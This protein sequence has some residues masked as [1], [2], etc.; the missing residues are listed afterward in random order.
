[1]NQCEHI[2]TLV[3]TWLDGELDRREQVECLDHVVR[4][5]SCRD[6]YLDARALD[7]LVAAVRTPAGAEPPSPEV[8]KRIE[9]AARGDRARPA[10]RR[11]PAWA[12]Q[13]A[14]VLVLAV[15]LSVVMWNGKGVAPTPE[16][17]EIL[18]GSDP[19][20]T[21]TRFVELTREVLQADPRYH[22]A[23]H[24]IM[25]RVV[26]ETGNT[27]EASAEGMVQRP[28][29]GEIGEDGESTGRIPA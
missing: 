23:M 6:F 13:A 3:S 5:A 21:E 9:G 17:A 2:E 25:E 18:L 1:M 12:L 19:E 8:W 22:T 4:C 20:M 26:S 10:R 11:I 15:G 24:Q 14:A 28:D 7:G 16:Q 27:A 29:E